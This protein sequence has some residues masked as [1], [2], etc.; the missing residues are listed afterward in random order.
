MYGS[1]DAAHGGY[2]L[3]ACQTFKFDN[4]EEVLPETFRSSFGDK[5]QQEMICQSCYLNKRFSLDMSSFHCIVTKEL[6]IY[7]S[8]IH[9]S[10][11][12]DFGQP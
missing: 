7:V 9:L 2:I 4:E 6:N 11:E 3:C 8:Y 5:A 12:N 10:L 1:T